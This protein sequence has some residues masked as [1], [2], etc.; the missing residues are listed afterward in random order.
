MKKFLCLLAAILTICGTMTLTSCSSTD[1]AV[2]TPDKSRQS[3]V[4]L[5][6][7]DVHCAINGYAKMAGLRDAVTDTAW[8]ALVSSG[9]FL[10]GGT[11]GAISHGQY[12]TDI[13]SVMHYDAV[14]LGNHE[15][16][17]GVSPMSSA[18]MSASNMQSLRDVSLFH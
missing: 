17:Y 16:D 5:F 12:V 18:A 11:S 7:T 2:D 13:M 9:D 6:E 1:N 8:A 15:F 14:T 3:I 4:I 10:Q